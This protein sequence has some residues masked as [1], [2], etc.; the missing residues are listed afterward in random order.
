VQ[1]TD[2]DGLPEFVD[3]WG[4][5][6]QFYRWPVGYH[7]DSQKGQASYAAKTETREKSSLD[8][9]SELMAPAWWA[10]ISGTDP[11]GPSYRAHLMS[12]SFFNLFECNFPNAS[13][14]VLWDRQNVYGRRRE[15]YT[16]YLIVSSGPD[17]AL[18]LVQLK[19]QTIRG[20][21]VTNVM[22]MLLGNFVASSPFLTTPPTPGESW[23]VLDPLPPVPNANDD[24]LSSHLLD[25]PGG[26]AAP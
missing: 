25:L 24:D 21:A 5:P 1:D 17:K 26:G 15:Y 20:T 16:K 23:A 19:D 22:N 2:G 9:N 13:A 12:A 6:L 3:A 14:G 8:P 10:D 11:T 7:S 4:E 18:G